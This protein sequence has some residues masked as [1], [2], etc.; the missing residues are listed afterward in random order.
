MLED[1]S[2]IRRTKSGGLLPDP[3]ELVDVVQAAKQASM[4]APAGV[5]PL[6]GLMPPAGI[7]GSMPPNGGVPMGAPL[8]GTLTRG[9]KRRVTFSSDPPDVSVVPTL[10]P[11]VALE[12][13]ELCV[14][15]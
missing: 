11:D 5:L 13:D 14:K 7:G 12:M 6:P 1:D 4:Q 9:G 8:G 3:A 15:L 10:V 2:Q